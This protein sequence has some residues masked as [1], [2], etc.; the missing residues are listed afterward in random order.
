MV[1]SRALEAFVRPSPVA[2]AGSALS[3]SYDL[4]ETFFSLD[5]SPDETLCCDGIASIIFMPDYLLSGNYDISISSGRYE[6][7]KGNQTISWWHDGRAVQTFRLR[8]DF[9]LKLH[10]NGIFSTPATSDCS[11]CSIS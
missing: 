10:G 7:D 1:G 3:Y 11:K 5:I 9:H 4:K 2:I 8:S 6:V